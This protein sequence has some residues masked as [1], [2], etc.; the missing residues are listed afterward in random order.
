VDTDEERKLQEA[1]RVRRAEHLARRSRA[2][3]N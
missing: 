3:E 1:A 2:K